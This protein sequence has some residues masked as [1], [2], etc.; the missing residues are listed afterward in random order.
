[1]KS[2]AAKIA[3]TLFALW[4]G[5]VTLSGCASGG[6]HL[7]RQYAR[8]VNRQN[9]II[10]IVLYIL[11]SVIF[12]VTLLIDAVIF[13]TMDFWQGR[14][15]QGTYEFQSEGKNYVVTH[16]YQPTTNLRESTISIS[17]G[18]LVASRQIILKENAQKEIDVWVDGTLK[19]TVSSISELPQISYY[20][21]LG[22]KSK[23]RSLWPESVAAN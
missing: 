22:V 19:A 12:A 5:L 1:M 2:F 3:V 11:T 17:G 9:L 16:R 6:Y 10:R 21:D 18:E 4:T 15:S 23:T 8:F 7:T 20:N 14:V 13:N